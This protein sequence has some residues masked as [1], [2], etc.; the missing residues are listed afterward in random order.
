MSAGAFWTSVKPEALSFSFSAAGALMWLGLA[1]WD[2]VI[3]EAEPEPLFYLRMSVVT[4]WQA[5]RV[6]MVSLL[7]LSC[8]GIFGWT[9]YIAHSTDIADRVLE[10]VREWL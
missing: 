10:W 6:L 8:L 9:A 1:W 2:M 3:L 4:V 5:H 7:A